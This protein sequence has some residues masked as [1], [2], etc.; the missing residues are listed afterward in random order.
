MPSAPPEPRDL[1][2]LLRAPVSIITP[3]S[4]V[5]LRDG[6]L[7]AGRLPECDVVIDDGLVSR[8]HA[9]ISVR[10]DAVMVEDLHSTN[11]VY[12]NGNRITH[13]A[14]LREGDRL[15]LGTTEISLFEA[16]RDARVAPLRPAQ[17][18]QP[19]R[20]DSDR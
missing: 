14:L 2:P 10:D 16:R 13:N 15:L 18:R 3:F 1:A 19:E 12:V 6:S 9:R 11:G 8:M 17:P 20:S 5:E 4:E 7:L